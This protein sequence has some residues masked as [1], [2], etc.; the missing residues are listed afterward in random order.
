MTEKKQTGRPKGRK[1]SP[2]VVKNR[3]DQKILELTLQNVPVRDIAKSADCSTTT[4]QKVRKQFAMVLNEL[5]DVEDYRKMRGSI[6]DAS[7]MALLKSALTREKL[8]KASLRDL[9][10]SFGILYDKGRLERGQSTQNVNK[11]VQFTDITA[12]HL[13]PTGET[14]EPSEE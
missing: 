1:D 6:L 13:R 5:N 14:P 12:T 4:V 9:M 7:Q 3:R 10:V 11:Q 8:D 2:E